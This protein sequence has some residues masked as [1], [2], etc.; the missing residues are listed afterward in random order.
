[1]YIGVMRTADTTADQLRRDLIMVRR[2][3]A[4]HRDTPGAK[5]VDTAER[6]AHFVAVARTHGATDA[7]IHTA[8]A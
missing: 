7:D 2:F 5:G 6:L 1:M 3:A 8:T 4:I